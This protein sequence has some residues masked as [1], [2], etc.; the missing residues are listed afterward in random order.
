MMLADLPPISSETRL[1]DWAHSSITRLPARVEPVKETLSTRGWVAIA[2][3]TTGPRPVTRLK[4]PAGTPASWMIS[5]RM[6]A[7]IGATSLGLSTTVQP[8]A[9]AGATLS[10]I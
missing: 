7:L 2:S 10:A 1:S 3:P 8:A 5:A 9:S 4:T 6:K